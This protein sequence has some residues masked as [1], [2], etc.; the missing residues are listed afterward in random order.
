L[1]GNKNMAPLAVVAIVAGSLFATGTAVKPYSPAVGSTMQAAGVGTLVG[2]AIGAAAGAG[3]GLAG[4]IGT[5]TTA[6]TVALSAG[7]GAGTGVV[8]DRY[9]VNNF[10]R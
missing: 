6:G 10:N 8:V 2:G 4:A 3:S 1:K 7:I 9:Y 5:S